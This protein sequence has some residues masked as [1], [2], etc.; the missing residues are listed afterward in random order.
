MLSIY[1]SK[2]QIP[3]GLVEH[4][5]KR[6]DGKYEPQVEGINSI[7]GIIAKRDEL[8]EK[9]REIPTLKSR[10]ME[11]EGQ[12]TLPKGKIAVDKK[13]FETLKAEHES[14]AALGNLD[15]IKPKVEG[16]DELRQ[17]DEARTREEAY[18]NAAKAAGYDEAKFTLLAERDNLQTVIKS[19]TENGKAVDKV[20]VKTTDD[21]G[22]EVETALSDYVT[23][24][25]TFKPFADSLTANGTTTGQ[26]I[27]RQG[28]TNP[29][30]PTI[31][32]EKEAVRASGAYS[33]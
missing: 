14:F 23:Q 19:V 16:Y 4:Y 21:K 29:A 1:D 7:G 18:R 3:E 26:K 5:T 25:A 30:T 13:E 8:L 15:E 2:D 32:T 20:F 6:S 31:E 27:I 9:V 33:F 24:S 28:T 10:V 11:L 12:E 22:K 17:K